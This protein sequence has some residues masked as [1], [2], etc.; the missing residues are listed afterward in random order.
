MRRK[1]NSKD[2]IIG[3]EMEN[4]VLVEIPEFYLLTI[5]VY[6][7]MGDGDLPDLMKIWAQKVCK[8]VGL[9]EEMIKMQN[10]KLREQEKRLRNILGDDMVNDIH[11]TIEDTIKKISQ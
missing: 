4:K 2:R 5:A 8:E 1:N 11:N 6:G 7:N 9:H 3:G 10:E